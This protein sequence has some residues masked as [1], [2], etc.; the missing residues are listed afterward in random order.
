MDE[1]HA[2]SGRVSR[3]TRPAIPLTPSRPDGTSR[4]FSSRSAVPEYGPCVTTARQRSLVSKHRSLTLS[5][6]SGHGAG[7]GLALVKDDQGQLQR[8]LSDLC[9]AEDPGSLA[10]RTD[11]QATGS[12][13]PRQR[14]R[15]GTV[16]GI[17]VIRR[18]TAPSSDTC[19]A[20]VRSISVATPNSPLSAESELRSWLPTVLVRRCHSTDVLH[21]VARGWQQGHG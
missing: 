16:T 1:P 2:R 17:G 13:G 5:R 6:G 3:F 18:R 11:L 10:L 4:P 19:S 15:A 9:D 21:V 8:R 12:T 7:R 14:G 20:F